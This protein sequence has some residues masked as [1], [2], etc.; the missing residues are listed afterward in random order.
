[1]PHNLD[2][3][4]PEYA[5]VE[6]KCQQLIQWQVDLLNLTLKHSYSFKRWKTIAN[7]M[8]HKEAGNFKIH[9]L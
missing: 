7:V 6:E 9:R 8:L 2:K 5:L 3:N 4:D 1:M